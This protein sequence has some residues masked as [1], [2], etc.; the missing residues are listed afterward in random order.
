MQF[1]E[2]PSDMID[3]ITRQ[4]HTRGLDVSDPRYGQQAA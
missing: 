2:M 4:G 1:D 3:A